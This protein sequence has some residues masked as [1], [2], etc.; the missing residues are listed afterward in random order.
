M[1]HLRTRLN[2]GLGVILTLGFGVQWGLR[3]YLTPLI[4]EQQMMTRLNHDI[5][6]LQDSIRFDANG[7]LVIDLAK[8]LPVYRQLHSGHYFIVES[9]SDR[10]VSPSAGEEPVQ[11]SSLLPDEERRS[12]TMGPHGQPLLVSGKGVT[13]QGRA[14]SISVGEDLSDLDHDVTEVGTLFLLLNGVTI[15]LALIMQWMF[16]RRA[17]KPFTLLSHE[18]YSL[19]Q[20]QGQRGSERREGR[21]QRTGG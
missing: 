3:N 1:R 9:G 2:A 7:V 11:M 21:S 8:Q 15:G 12:H 19:G 6:A 4:A 17:L 14:V 18:L 13:L 5:D 20:G 16:V 10:E